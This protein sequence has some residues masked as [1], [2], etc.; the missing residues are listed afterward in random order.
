[1]ESEKP[2]E[3][4]LLLCVALTKHAKYALVS[5]NKPPLVKIIVRWTLISSR[6]NAKLYEPND[7]RR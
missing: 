1:M 6:V 2:R 4:S 3:R 5:N 7:G